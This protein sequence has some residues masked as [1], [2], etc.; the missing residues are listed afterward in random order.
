MFS[1]VVICDKL[2]N[3]RFSVNENAKLILYV[4]EEMMADITNEVSPIL[5]IGIDPYICSAN[6]L[7]KTGEELRNILI[8]F[9][10]E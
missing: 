4:N 9:R 10:S 3:N 8:S 2:E 7:F 1:L 5:D 6:I